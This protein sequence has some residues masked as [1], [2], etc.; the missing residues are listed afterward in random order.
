M[1]SVCYNCN[2]YHTIIRER[3]G[4]MKKFIPIMMSLLLLLALSACGSDNTKTDANEKQTGKASDLST[5]EL[6]EEAI[7]ANS[8]LNSFSIEMIM[9]M[10]IEGE[11]QEM[12]STIAMDIVTDPFSFRQEMAMAMDL[13]EMPGTM[14][15]YL[16]NNHL[17]MYDSSEEQWMK[18]P[19]EFSEEMGL[20]DENMDLGKQLSPFNEYLDDF[21]VTEDKDN[22]MLTLNDMDGERFNELLQSTLP[23]SSATGMD[24]AELFGAIDFK[25]VE[26][27]LYFDKDT[28]LFNASDIYLSYDLGFEDEQ[29][30]IEQKVKATYSKHNEIDEITIPQN[31]LDTAVEM[32]L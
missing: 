3:D 27:V 25:Q 14:E 8:D 18:F 20:F 1:H 32:E 6:L 29:G 24:F 22:Y 31:A 15:M 30:T 9:D 28:F 26:Y 2:R 12:T 16:V 4:F 10:D 5:K 13:E 19:A 7:A 21:T 23:N 17:Y 11:Q